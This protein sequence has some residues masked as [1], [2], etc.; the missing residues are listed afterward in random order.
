M[1]DVLGKPIA[2]WSRCPALKTVGL[3]LKNNK[4]KN[5]TNQVN[6]S[7]GT[8]SQG[9]RNSLKE[10]GRSLT[11]DGEGKRRECYY[12]LRMVA[13]FLELTYLALLIIV[14][15]GGPL[16]ANKPNCPGKKH[17]AWSLFSSY[18]SHLHWEIYAELGSP[19]SL[20]RTEL[21][22]PV[23]VALRSASVCRVPCLSYFLHWLAVT[24]FFSVQPKAV[25]AE[26]NFVS[27]IFL[28]P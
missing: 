15:A 26:W 19:G 24:W 16:L 8:G 6:K 7:N 25:E 12:T 10:A 4:N 21:F 28:L 22:R 3:V 2:H 18:T 20:E 5:P 27:L 13:L 14:R 17:S 11:E 1:E 23:A 9:S